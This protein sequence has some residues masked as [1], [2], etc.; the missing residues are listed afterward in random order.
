MASHTPP[1]TNKILPVSSSGRC[2]RQRRPGRG[3]VLAGPVRHHRHIQDMSNVDDSGRSASL[4]PGGGL[5]Q[6]TRWAPRSTVT[7]LTGMIIKSRDDGGCADVSMVG[8]S[9]EPDRA[10]GIVV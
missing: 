6:V 3:S 1:A 10:P 7:L 4:R 2:H 8:V 5:S 9:R